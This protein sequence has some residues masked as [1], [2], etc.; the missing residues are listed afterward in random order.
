MNVS[1]VHE[2][3]ELAKLRN[4]VVFENYAFLSHSQHK[5]VKS[6]LSDLRIGKVRELRISYCYPLPDEGDIRLQPEMGAG[7]VHDSMGYP[8]ALAN[9]L[10]G[11]PISVTESKLSFDTTCQI[12]M[13]CEFGLRC[14]GIIPA[15]C[16]V[17]MG[18]DYDAKYKITGDLGEI[19]VLRAFSVNESQKT[20]IVMRTLGGVEEISVEP[21]NQFAKFINGCLSVLEMGNNNEQELAMLKVRAIMDQVLKGKNAE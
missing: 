8:I 21:E 13:K 6:L 11:G 16:V 2:V 9:Y 10:F 1:E 14:N 7:V 20:M 5:I 18:C 4:R 12:V 15:K 3:L 19:E 17:A